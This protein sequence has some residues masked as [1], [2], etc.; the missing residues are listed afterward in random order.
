[1]RSKSPSS[2]FFILDSANLMP[3]ARVKKVPLVRRPQPE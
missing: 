2:T 3:D 1:M